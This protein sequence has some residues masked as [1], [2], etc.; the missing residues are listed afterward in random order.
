[1]SE[2]PPAVL[3]LF[4][5]EQQLRILGEL[6]LRADEEYPLSRLVERTGVSQQTVSREVDRLVEAGFVSD[7]RLG[8]MRLVRANRDGLYFDELSSMLRKAVGPVPVLRRALQAIPGIDEAYVYGSWARRYLGDAGPEP[9]DV[10]VLV[11]GDVDVDRVTRA[12]RRTEKELGREVNPT[13][14]SA[15]EWRTGRSGFLTELRRDPL[16]PILGSG[17]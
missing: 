7:R 9:Q 8:R 10:D 14:V 1:V 16:V 6:Y 4:R 3:P 5:S 13:V 2:R 15:S 11:V 12:C 17:A